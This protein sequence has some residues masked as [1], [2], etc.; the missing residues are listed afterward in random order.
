MKHRASLI[1]SF[2]FIEVVSVYFSI[3]SVKTTQL[4]KM[5]WFFVFLHLQLSMC[6]FW[7]LVFSF[8]KVNVHLI[9]CYCNQLKHLIYRPSLCPSTGTISTTE[10]YRCFLIVILYVVVRVELVAVWGQDLAFFGLS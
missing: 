9:S 7:S 3:E 4:N 10:T 2:S 6:W 1:T 5:H 8:V